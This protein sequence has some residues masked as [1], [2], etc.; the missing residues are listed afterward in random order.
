MKL[1]FITFGAGNSNYHDAVKRICNQARKFNIF[2]NILGFTEKDLQDN[3]PFWENHGEFILNNPRGYGYWIWKCFLIRQVMVERQDI[4]EG[5]II[6]Y[7]D[8]GCELNINGRQRMFQYINL[9]MTHDLVAFQME[10]L[11]EKKYTKMDLLDYSNVSEEDRN[12][13]QIVGGINFWKKTNKNLEILNEIINLLTISNYHFIDDSPSVKQNDP[14]FIDHRH[15]QS[16]ISVTLKK[17]KAYLLK[18]E[19][20]FTDWKDGL[21]FPILALRNRTG[22]S[23]F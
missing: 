6:L 22:V 11:N 12:S 1:H 18:D 9:A 20:Y 13:G 21:T 4:E 5:D 16:C 7:V 8:S 17:H 19:T 10:N 23:Y 3:K 14:I 15:D 2:K